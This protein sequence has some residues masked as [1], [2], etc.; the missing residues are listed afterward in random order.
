M[1]EEKPKT[2][3]PAYRSLGSPHL[4]QPIKIQMWLN[5]DRHQIGIRSN[6]Q[7]VRWNTFSNSWTRL[8]CQTEAPDFEQLSLEDVSKPILINCTCSHVSNYAVLMDI[9]DPEDIPEPSLL[10]QISSYSAFMLSLPILFGVLLAL[11]LLRGMQTNSNTIH[12]NLV[13]C[14]FVAELLFFVSMQARRELLNDEFSCKM[15]A[16][17]LHYA[18]LAAFAWTTVDCM[19][20]YRM[21]TEMRDINHGPMGFYFSMGYGAPAIIVGLSVGVRAHEYGNSLL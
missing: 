14:V 2:E 12:Q 15:I 19:H 20:L 11:A 8:G 6:P 17:C 4:T 9:I 16:I 7:C 1:I 10:V 21:L 18:W 3:S 5:V 13:L